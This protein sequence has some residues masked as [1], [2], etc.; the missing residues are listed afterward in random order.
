MINCF[1]CYKYSSLEHLQQGYQREY[2][3]LM[4]R[5]LLYD[6]QSSI[7]IE[8]ALSITIFTLLQNTL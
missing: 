5:T 3:R 8:D 6:T 2:H 1:F 7:T 4:I